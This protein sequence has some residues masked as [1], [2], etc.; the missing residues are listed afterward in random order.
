[1]IG[2]SKNPRC[3]G[4]RQEKRKFAYFDQAKAWSDTKTFTKWFHEV[5]LPHI[6]STT[7]EKVLLI[8]DNCGPHGANISDPHG[9]VR[10]I[11]LPP[12][13]TAVHKSN[14]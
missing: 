8:M 3:F 5:F 13:C 10:I 2:T 1:M 4:R 11:T 6:R 7:K 12:N 9:Q 14:S